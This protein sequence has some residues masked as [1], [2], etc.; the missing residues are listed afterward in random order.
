MLTGFLLEKLD[1]FTELIHVAFNAET[2]KEKML[3]QARAIAQEITLALEEELGFDI[4]PADG[5]K[6]G[7]RI[8][9][10][11][12]EL[13]TSTELVRMAGET[14]VKN[15]K[16]VSAAAIET[17]K[18]AMAMAITTSQSKQ[19]SYAQATQ[20]SSHPRITARENL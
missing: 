3:F 5:K 1:T 12:N 10:L 14:A 11:V 13:K 15:I 2:V 17:S 4:T 18:T 20:M 19:L 8:S 6:L 9:E 16:E 7:N